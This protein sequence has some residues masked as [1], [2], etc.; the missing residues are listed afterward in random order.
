[1]KTYWLITLEVDAAKVT[2]HL[3]ADGPIFKA[4]ELK[5]QYGK[6]TVILFAMQLTK[7]Q[8]EHFKG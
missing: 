8:Y 3:L 4:S 6:F 1:M 2:G 5:E 7:E